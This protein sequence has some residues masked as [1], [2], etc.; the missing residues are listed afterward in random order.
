M[1]INGTTLTPN[2]ERVLRTALHHELVR[3]SD[4]VKLLDTKDVDRE[5]ILRVQ[6]AL[7]LTVDVIWDLIALVND[8]TEEAAK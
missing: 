3:Y 5:S 2:Q 6:T 1:Q 8:A 7:G 4:S